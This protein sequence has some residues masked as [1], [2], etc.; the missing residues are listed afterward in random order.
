MI[1]G[2]GNSRD[3]EVKAPDKGGSSGGIMDKCL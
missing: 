2:I 1:P 3:G